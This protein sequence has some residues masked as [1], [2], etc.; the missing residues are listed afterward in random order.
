MQFF[1]IFTL[2]T[3][4]CIVI[5]EYGMYNNNNN[6]F[7]SFLISSKLR[8]TK[9][10]YFFFY[11]QATMHTPHGKEVVCQVFI[12]TDLDKRNNPFDFGVAPWDLCTYVISVDETSEGRKIKIKFNIAYSNKHNFIWIFLIMICLMLNPQQIHG[13]QKI[14]Y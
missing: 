7:F 5:T 4:F 3:T 1:G 14:N 12:Q 10:I 2:T 8:E 11:H 6:L 13:I 9:E